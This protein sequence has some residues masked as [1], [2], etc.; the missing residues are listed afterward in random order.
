M[1]RA[2]EGHGR[3]QV[4]GEKR[5]STT[6]SRESWLASAARLLGPLLDRLSPGGAGIVLPGRPSRA[7]EASDRLEGLARSLWIAGPWLAAE[8][9]A[10]IDRGTA[11]TNLGEVYRRALLAGTSQHSAESWHRQLATRQTLVEACA[12][13]WNVWVARAALWEPLERSE[14]DAV[15]DW[16]SRAARIP[17]HDNNWRLFSV[18]LLTVLRRLGAPSSTEEVLTHLEAVDSFYV[19]DGWYADGPSKAGRGLALDYYNAWVLHPY[20][21]FWSDLDGDS[22]PEL[23]DRIRE[24]AR[25]FLGT[26]DHFFGVDGSYPCFGRSALYRMAV[27]APFGAAVTAGVCPV[28]LGRARRLCRLVRERFEREPGVFDQDGL[29]TL[30]FHR[31]Y[32]PM[33]E[34]Y[35]G[36]GSPYWAGKAFGVLALPEDHEFWQA[37][38]EPLPIEESDFLVELPAA[39]FLVQGTAETG[40]VQLLNG[41][42]L[43]RPK[44]YSNLAYSSCFGYEIAGPPSR[45]AADLATDSSLQL[46]LESSGWYSRTE[47]LETRVEGGTLAMSS[48]FRIGERGVEVEVLSAS[49]FLGD[50]L[51]CLHRVRAAAPVQAREGG[52]ACGWHDGQVEMASDRLSYVTTRSAASGIRPLA[53]YDRVLMPT[54]GDHNVRFELSAIPI[55]ETSRFARIWELASVSLARPAGF[56]PE[57]LLRVDEQA[58]EPLRRSLGRLGVGSSAT[59]GSFLERAARSRAGAWIR[60]FRRSPRPRGG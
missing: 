42:S 52:Y 47:V 37:H 2:G 4:L 46:R 7:G 34:R 5:P 57:A 20:L 15:V 31:A 14:R 50:L 51:I 11:S 40:H 39:G 22:A 8:P 21:L 58:L 10:R 18:I 45:D 53:G 38:E 1:E 28:A 48:R 24:R 16:L 23:R 60:R 27:T 54:R 59:R 6:G 30:G 32:P 43:S 49:S 44:K 26:F 36:P 35:S 55:V 56:A 33:V 25:S 12:I 13:A 19:G 3:P 29:L 9:E 17:P 41:R